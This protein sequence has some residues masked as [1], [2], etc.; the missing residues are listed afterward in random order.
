VAQDLDVPLKASEATVDL[1][2]GVHVVEELLP[3]DLPVE[4]VE[5][6]GSYV[7]FDGVLQNIEAFRGID[8]KYLRGSRQRDPE[9]FAKRAGNP[10]GGD[11]PLYSGRSRAANEPAMP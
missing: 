10:G 7:L 2:V 11:L 5:A 8:A 4:L 3:A 6:R 9:S 1:G